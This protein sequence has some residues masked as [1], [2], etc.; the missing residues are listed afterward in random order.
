M[1]LLVEQSIVGFC[2]RRDVVHEVT[3]VVHQLRHGGTSVIPGNVVMQLFP[4]PFD[5]ALLHKSA[6]RSCRLESADGQERLHIQVPN[7][8]L[9]GV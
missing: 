3:H 8:E 6:F 5:G 9:V 2:E 4:K 1:S 7:P